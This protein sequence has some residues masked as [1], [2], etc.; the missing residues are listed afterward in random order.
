MYGAGSVGCL[1]PH[2]FRIGLHATRVADQRIGIRC[3]FV[4]VRA[5]EGLQK[6]DKLAP[7]RQQLAEVQCQREVSFY[8]GQ[9]S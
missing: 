3:G 2:A 5:F 7:F 8:S 4:A 1:G 9:T 6:Q